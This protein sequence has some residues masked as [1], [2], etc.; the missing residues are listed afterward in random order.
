MS[1]FQG[2]Q[3]SPYP[4]CLCRNIKYWHF[5]Y[6]LIRVTNTGS[7]TLAVGMRSERTEF[8]IRRWELNFDI[9]FLTL[10]QFC[11]IQVITE[12]HFFIFFFCQDSSCYH[13]IQY[14]LPTILWRRIE[15]GHEKRYIFEITDNTDVPLG[16]YHQH[17][18]L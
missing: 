8:S 15:T 6:I 11:N 10:T 16:C 18:S 1:W 7:G 17:V 2:P 13:N 4:K 14:G 5:M 9:T 3:D 12:L